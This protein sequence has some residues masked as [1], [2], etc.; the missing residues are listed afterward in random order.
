M[1]E[2]SRAAEQILASAGGGSTV[3]LLESPVIS[4]ENHHTRLLEDFM[5]LQIDNSINKDIEHSTGVHMV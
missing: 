5:K 2:I 4:Y 3:Q 1:L